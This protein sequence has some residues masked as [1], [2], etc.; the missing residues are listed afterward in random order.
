MKKTEVVNIAAAID[1]N[2]GLLK[3]MHEQ[4]IQFAELPE[5]HYLQPTSPE[6]EAVLCSTCTGIMADIYKAIFLR[7][8]AKIEFEPADEGDLVLTEA[9]FDRV[10]TASER[11]RVVTQIGLEN[12][13]EGMRQNGNTSRSR[14]RLRQ[15]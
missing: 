1:D 6:E 2:P 8:T 3:A 10:V 11:A 9:D 14:K 15:A 5:D 4:G 12:Y 7:E 13:Q